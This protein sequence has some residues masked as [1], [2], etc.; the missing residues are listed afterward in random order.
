MQ[1]AELVKLDLQRYPYA[2]FSSTPHASLT[3]FSFRLVEKEVWEG[4][5]VGGGGVC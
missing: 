5:M 3:K 4:G 1:P 2:S